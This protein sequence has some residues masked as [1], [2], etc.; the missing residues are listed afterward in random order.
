MKRAAVMAAIVA[1]LV[2]AI[3]PA[4][5]TAAGPTIHGFRLADAPITRGATYQG[6]KSR[7]GKLA[8][9][10]PALI[11]RTDSKMV[12]VMVKFDA[13][14][15]ASYDGGVDGFKA[16][17]PEVTGKT[18]KQNRSAVRAYERHLA[19]VSTTIETGIKARVPSARLGRTF[20]TA[21]GGVAVRLPANRAKDL[22]KVKGVVA[23]Q[24]DRLEQ[25][26][27]TT[28]ASSVDYVGAPK[29]WSSLGGSRT[30]GQGVTVGIL[31]TGIWPEHPMLADPGIAPPGGTYGCQFGDGSDPLLG[32]PFAC[33]DKLIGAYA[34]LDTY[35]SVYDPETGEF[36]DVPAA[37]CSPR[38][39]DGHGTHTATTAA[40]S[41]VAH[42]PL[43]GVDRGPVSGIAPGAHVIAYRV[44]LTQGCFQSDSVAAIQQ[45]ILDGVDVINFSI[46][47]GTSA[48]TDPVELAF[49]DAYANGISVNAS[50][51]NDGPGASTV[52]HN[53]PW[54]TTVAASTYDHMYLTTLRLRASNG[55][56]LN[57]SGSDIVPGLTH[58]TSVVLASAV[59]QPSTCDDP[60]PTGSVT[61]KVV[62]CERGVIGR[63]EKSFNVLQGGAAGM[64]LYNPTL[65]SLF[66]D[67]FWVP[68]VMIEG[69]QPAAR[70]LAFIRSHHGVTA[71]WSTGTLKPVRGDVMAQ[72]SSRGPGGDF[73]KPDVTAP[74]LQI[75]AGHTPASIDVATGPT[76]ELYQA[77]SG[78][79]MSSPHATG[80]SALIKAAHPSWT[81]GQI[82]SALMTSSVQ[83]VLKENGKKSGPFDRGAGS[84]RVNRA[85]HPTVT[86]D[87][88]AA[89]Y[90]A[91]VG[92][93][94]SRLDLNLPS[95]D[96]DPMPGGIAT[97]RTVKNVSGRRQVFQVRISQPKGVQI[98]VSPA[99][100]TLAR[101]HSRTLTIRIRASGAKDG[102][103][104]GQITLDPK[105]AGATSA[106]LPVAFYRS[107]GQ[108]T[109][110][111]SCA[112][113][114]LRRNA[115]TK[116]T[117]KAT[118]LAS[119]AAA[120]SL[121]VRAPAHL[122]ISSVSAPGAPSS[123]G[124]SWKGSLSAAIAPTV[125]SIADA[126]GT[127][128]AGGYLPLADYDIPAQ[129]GFGDETLVNYGVPAFK[130]GS[131]TYTTI[132][133][134]SNGY[135]VLGGGSSQDNECCNVQTFP[136]PTRPNNVLAPYWTDLDLSSSGGGAFKIATLDDG[137]NVY[138]ILEWEAAHAYGTSRANTF[139][140]WIRTGDTEGIWYTFDTL[141][142]PAGGALLNTG[143]ENRD[144][145]SGVNLTGAPTAED[146]LITTSPPTPGGSV[147]ITYRA[148]STRV[149]RYTVPAS[150]TADVVRGTAVRVVRLTVR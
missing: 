12:T 94:G 40:G 56:T 24:S 148:S 80:V 107:Q 34:F 144:G 17:S 54:V 97:T 15:V 38:D 126:G 52:E 138:L 133:V 77:I 90:Y 87:V 101:G 100:F 6:V 33:N 46:G 41:P 121:D 117:V 150:M 123:S 98:L 113:S 2:G 42:A 85:V 5:A 35:L 44:C 49:L 89:A 29:V 63:N 109:L 78:T 14:A 149:G 1:L 53:G 27:G 32:A 92:D 20:T 122:D 13:D 91:S 60:F 88:P 21:Y 79:S 119:V 106:V 70:M 142:G 50:A 4:G 19:S 45:A 51:G 30:A 104:F 129:A 18:L 141:D 145:S 132:G 31:D 43:L 93:S 140:I 147:T 72:F 74:G 16:T 118:N 108:V 59:G 116:C 71:R 102:W 131:E 103:Y 57:I 111:H 110:S 81:P 75:L 137:L 124:L 73:L 64:I 23:V 28:G 39:A 26:A 22:L 134:D 76:G 139:Q 84:I 115:S 69:R 48:F 99:T 10:D 96:A 8:R 146:Y 112:A 61:G 67:N 66:T 120:V 58:A 86:F 125:D 95:I 3:A 128:P 143:A 68:S 83:D 127:S 65:Q 82:K 25:L 9:S 36:C 7:S 135:A 62:V 37:T 130:F 55:A 105:R 136:D 11:A 114:T 47:G